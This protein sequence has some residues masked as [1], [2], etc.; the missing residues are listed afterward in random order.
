[1]AAHPRSHD[2]GAAA[3]RTGLHPHR[4]RLG[5]EGHWAG[6]GGGCWPRL[7]S[8]SHTCAP[9]ALRGHHEDS[10]PSDT[11]LSRTRTRACRLPARGRKLYPRGRRGDALG[12]AG[13]QLERPGGLPVVHGWCRRVFVGFKAPEDFLPGCLNDGCHRPE[14]STDP[15]LVCSVLGCGAAPRCSRRD[16]AALGYGGPSRASRWLTSRGGCCPPRGMRVPLSHRPVRGTG[17]RRGSLP[18]W[19][20]LT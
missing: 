3:V 10:V 6:A 16:G 1:M 15:A 13:V 7:G 14:W 2:H 4:D 8:G 18:L 17:G 20:S 12:R 5:L 19:L 11:L 9:S